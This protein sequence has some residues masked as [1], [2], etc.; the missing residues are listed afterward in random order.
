MSRRILDF[1]CL[2]ALVYALLI[3]LQAFLG[4]LLAIFG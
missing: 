3:G 2:D 4:A 1:I